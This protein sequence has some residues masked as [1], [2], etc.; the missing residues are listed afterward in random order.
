MSW[1]PLYIVRKDLERIS[2]WLCAEDD[3]A[4]IT[5]IG[6]NHWKAIKDFSITEPGDYYLYH[7]PSGP[8]PLLDEKRRD[9]GNTISDPFNGW[10]GRS[11]GANEELPF[12]GSSD[13]A[14]FSLCIKPNTRETIGIS[15]FGWI[16]NH[17][18]IIGYPATDSSVKWWARLGRWV[19]KQAMRVPR[20]SEEKPEIYAF[21]HAHKAIKEGASHDTNP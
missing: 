6:N 13:Q 14:I 5:K 16:G 8:L 18:R 10:I 2:D 17:F 15:S 21:E 11:S 7:I 19:K 12:F 4:L 1:I 9:D 20:N 3:I